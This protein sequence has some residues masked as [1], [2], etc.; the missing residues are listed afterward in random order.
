MFGAAHRL[1]QYAEAARITPTAIALDEANGIAASLSE[2]GNV[3]DA[4]AHELQQQIV[5]SG[6]VPGQSFMREDGE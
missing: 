5:R 3:R 2:N 4:N 6:G 1:R